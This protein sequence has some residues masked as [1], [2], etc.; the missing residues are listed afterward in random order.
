MK[1]W[2][3]RL[4]YEDANIAYNQPLLSI[5]PNFNFI[6]FMLSYLLGEQ[7]FLFF[8]FS[9]NLYIWQNDLFVLCIIYCECMRVLR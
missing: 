7:K 3:S 4:G 6:L 5:L 2:E 9:I 8:Y 1:I